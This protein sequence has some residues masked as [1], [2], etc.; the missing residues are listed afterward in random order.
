MATSSS[1]VSTVERRLRLVLW[2][3]VGVGVVLLVAAVVFGLR[4]H[5]KTERDKVAQ[6]IKD[7]D[8]VEIRSSK[9]VRAIET[10]YRNFSAKGVSE[11]ANLRALRQ[12][13]QSMRV[14][15]RKLAAVDAP[16]E[17]AK[18]RTM[19]LRLLDLDI[20]FAGDVADLARFRPA[21]SRAQAPVASATARLR[22]AIS[23]SKTT[24][25]QRQAFDDYATSIR[26][27]AERVARVP[28]PE[29]FAP[30]SRAETARLR[31]LAA[32]AAQVSDALAKRDSQRATQ[33]FGQFSSVASSTDVIRAQRESA[34]A[35]NRKLTQIAK[36]AAAIDGERARLDRTLG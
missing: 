34:L 10:A 29:L 3:G 7:V 33:L 8:N 31:R 2:I 16:P 22:A 1:P 28:A 19:L 21:L 20:A 14:L 27:T 23:K 5:G 24:A 32:L 17:A 36:L 18:L 9:P 12:A 6:Y 4:P 11:S 35:Y 13:Q 30:V 15:R 26:A 25:A